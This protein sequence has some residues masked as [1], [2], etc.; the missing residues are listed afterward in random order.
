MSPGASRAWGTAR[1]LTRSAGGAEMRGRDAEWR[2]VGDL[3][4]RADGGSGGVLL[5]DGE[6]GMGKSLLLREA[7]HEGAAR[8]FSLATGAADQLGGQ[9][10]LFTLRMAVGMTS[11]D[12]DQ[13]EP[14]PLAAQIGR[15]R[16]RLVRRAETAPVLVM[17]DDLQWAGEETLLALRVLPRELARYPVAWILARSVTPRRVPQSKD[18]ECL[19]TAL[20]GEGAFRAAL[21]P[22]DSGIVTE[23]LSHAFGAAPDD[24]LLALASGAGGNPSLLADLIEGLREDEAIRLDG[25]HVGLA[26]ALLP[27]RVSRTARRWLDVSEPARRL[28][29][30]A[31]VLGGE[32]RL[33]DLAEVMATTPTA[34]LPHLEEALDA[35]IIVAREDAFSFRY[36]LMVRAAAESVPR[37]VR[38]VLH[39]H[40]G[41][42]LLDREGSAAEACA[43]LLNAA[44]PCDPASVAGLD[45]GAAR[46]LRLSPRM[47]ADL[48][49]RALQFTGPADRAAIPRAVAAAEA[50]A[51]AGQP[52]RA[53]RIAYET[54]ARP[55]PAPLEARIRS[56]L[57]SVLSMSGQASDAAAHAGKV[58]DSAD[59]HDAR[60]HAIVA[61][62]QAAT[63]RG[64]DRDA[65]RVAADVLA[66]A[67]DHSDHAV[68]AAETTRAMLKW[69]EGRTSEALELLREAARRG[70]VSPDARH[71]QPLLLLA[72]RMIDLRRLNEAAS[73]IHSAE[74]SMPDIG[75]IAMIV[76]VLR[77]RLH[78]ASGRFDEAGTE[79]ESLLNAAESAGA[80]AY[81][82]VARCLLASIA[83][84]QGRLHDADRDL[85]GRAV[86]P[87]HSAA[88]YAPAETCLAPAQ[89]TEAVK[90]ASAAI[91]QVLE[92]CADPG[93][94]RRVLLGDPAH[95]VWLVRAA[96]AA[97]D[98]ALA[99]RAV[100]A[101]ETLASPDTPAVAAAAAHARGLLTGDADSLTYAAAHHSDPWARASAAEDL[102]VL[103]IAKAAREEA[104]ARLNE[105]F[106][107]YAEVSAAA[108][109]AR[110]RARLRDLGVRR[111]HW[112]TSPDRPVDGWDSL[113]N[114][115]RAVAV[116]I[117]EGLTNQQAASR[118]YISAHTVA[119]H[120]RQA[121][122]KLR[123]G[124]RVEL[125]RIVMERAQQEM[126]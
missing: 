99:T 12:Y 9:L 105:A 11:D 77:A 7:G 48:A 27:R 118:M 47:A 26:S 51:A 69:D 96:L 74:D 92:L 89:V 32:F 65:D 66:V 112:E 33:G 35:G 45:N 109:L 40:F 91:G 123:I 56:A 102:G 2:L 31:A 106:E 126:A 6:H 18:A 116:L 94:L 103:G 117:A 81:A 4:R 20:E 73:L 42:I 54:L 58:L 53:A 1:P 46:I 115:E 121:F 41:E 108:D 61:W 37:P 119:H 60:D 21:Q 24:E 70:G 5:V 3:L 23:M 30:T 90:G 104:V 75:L 88:V 14:E 83:L 49:T 59:S 114:T 19:F 16:E 76:S 25:E 84:R 55:V 67:N 57:A 29:E 82:S 64:C 50:L 28:L 85:A 125:T 107:G 80:D 110:V 39:R 93:T 22:L 101:I 78:L 71:T 17:L 8:G 87:P 98:L 122:R 79:A 100:A 63:G 124:S 10:P 97:G 86:L 52:A 120:L 72:A 15:L 111:R 13:P 62:L 68:L 38:R 113:T 43:H 34:L 36:H 44:A 95:A